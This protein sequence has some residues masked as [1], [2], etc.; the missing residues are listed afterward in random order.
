MPQSA[1]ITEAE[2]FQP[3]FKVERRFEPSKADLRRIFF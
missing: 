1:V 3:V 2:N